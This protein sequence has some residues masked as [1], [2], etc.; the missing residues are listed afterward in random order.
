MNSKKAII[1][2]ISDQF[3]IDTIAQVIYENEGG[4]DNEEYEV[5]CGKPR[6]KWRIIKEDGSSPDWDQNVETELLEHE[7]DDYRWQAKAVLKKLNL[8]L[9]F[10][11]NE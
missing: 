4:M 7:R 3:L 2:E 5:V 10:E 8:L 9:T 6:K 11:T 1:P